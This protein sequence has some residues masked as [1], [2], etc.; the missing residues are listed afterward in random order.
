[1]NRKLL[2]FIPII[3]IAIIALVNV[4]S[5]DTIYDFEV[6]GQEDDWVNLY[7]NATRTTNPS[8]ILNDAASYLLY[9]LSDFEYI[10]LDNSSSEIY[11]NISWNDPVD[12]DGIFEFVIYDLYDYNSMITIVHA[13]L[14]GC[15]MGGHRLR[16]NKYS[17]PKEYVYEDW[18]DSVGDIQ[19][20]IILYPLDDLFDVYINDTL[21]VSKSSIECSNGF[22]TIR[23][24]TTSTSSTYY[25]V[26]DDIK[27]L[28]GA[29]A[30]VNYI[31]EDSV[32]VEG[33]F[34]NGCS[35]SCGYVYNTTL[36]IGESYNVT[37]GTLGDEGFSSSL[38]S[39]NYS[40]YYYLQT[41]WYD[42]DSSFHLSNYTHTFLTKPYPPLGLS[43]T[44][45][46]PDN[47][48]LEWTNQ[49]WR[50]GTNQTTLIRYSTSW[51]PTTTSSGTLAYNGTD[52]T[53]TLTGLDSDSRYY[54]SA[55]TYINASGSPY[56]WW[57]SDFYD[58][59]SEDPE[60][61]LFNITFMWECL[62][63]GPG[64]ALVDP[65]FLYNSTLSAEL[66][67]G[68][69]LYLNE[70]L[71]SNVTSFD[72]EENPDIF[73]F[74]FNYT[75]VYQ[76]RSVVYEDGV[77]NYTIYLCCFENWD[78]E[79]KNLSDWQLEYTFEF[80]DFTPDNIFSSSKYTY[81]QI[82]KYYN[83]TTMMTIHEDYWDAQ[84]KVVVYLHYGERYFLGVHND[85]AS[86]DFLQ[87]V[88]TLSDTIFEIIVTDDRETEHYITDYVIINLSRGAN[89][90]MINYTDVSFGTNAANLSIYRVYNNNDT[91]ELVYQYNYSSSD[92]DY[93][94]TSVNGFNRS[95]NYA[96]NFSINHTDFNSNQSYI[97]LSLASYFDPVIDV[98]WF[99][100]LFNQYVMNINLAFGVSVTQILLFMFCFM[101]LITVGGKY[102]SVG[103]I[104]TG[105]I[106]C[107]GLALLFND[108]P[109]ISAGGMI[110]G[111][112]FIIF[113]IL[114]ARSDFK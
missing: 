67:N 100:D 82:Y 80:S 65:Y 46:D 109:L 83:T 111:V 2:F 93:L 19:V 15:E 21:V 31:E 7:G 103:F 68:E 105:L 14:G 34:F 110:I 40:D 3:L 87:Y 6:P 77:Y 108:G 95:W 114:F 104:V 62:D 1:M 47:F 96:L 90:L 63:K 38:S 59:E 54:F 64:D 39:L 78:Y 71:V 35:S 73:R 51:Y 25:A 49:T 107:D 23:L 18:Y 70:S 75:N 33:G 44:D 113:G 92:E 76:T 5:A 91:A 69:K 12:Y 17:Y 26:Y 52:E 37:I 8:L 20:H 101:T 74:V 79:D 72:L 55:W 4:T 58:T 97:V 61:G 106:L 9:G 32:A 45:T 16:V 86:I 88:D 11:V 27:I 98:D 56:Y 24:V 53:C 36:P 99:N 28:Y 57:F 85:D 84:D 42:A 112:L 66:I 22:N 60:G 48:V 94:W 43:I 10:I 89:Y 50:A 30:H 102:P 81:L 13:G 29:N 41:W